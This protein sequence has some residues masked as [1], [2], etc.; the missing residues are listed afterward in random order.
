MKFKTTLILLVVF[1]L[2]LVGVILIEHRSE[3]AQEKREREAKLT[4]YQASEVEKI[5]L[6]SESGEKI[7]IERDQT[8]HWKIIEPL[9]AEADEYEINSLVE[10]FASLSFEKVVEEE[11]SDP[12][13]YEIPKKDITFWL[14]GHSQPI[15][16]QIGMENPI[17][18]TLYAKRAD[19]SQVVLLPGHLK[20]SLDKT[21]FDF[22]KK[23]IMT[24]DTT[25]VLAIELRAKENN[26]KVKRR[27]ENWYFLQPGE[28]LAS[29]SKIEN[30]LDSLSRLRA[31]D[32][33]AENKDSQNLKLFGLDKP[34]FT[35][36]LTLPESQEIT[37]WLTRQD[38]KV[39]VTNSLSKKIIEVDSQII[40]DLSQ[41]LTDLREKKVAV[42]NS[43]EAVALSLKQETGK[44]SVVKE[45]VKEKGQEEEK[46]FLMTAGGDK[47]PV[48]D[49]RVESLL[50]NLEYLEATD[51][52]DNPR[53]LAE[54]GLDRPSLEIT[55][56][57]RTD[58]DE[59][60]EL[61]LLVGP[62]NPET[63]QVVIK[64]Q[65]LPYL[66]RV[67]ASFLKEIPERPEDWKLIENNNRT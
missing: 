23:D 43:W 22:R 28:A 54:Y 66:F 39:T 48:D 64:N 9:E 17:D 51:F 36:I 58:G 21:L 56:R 31:K 10:N 30:L 63:H 34:E 15:T 2:L 3:R 27:E 5:S 46:W 6:K 13:L 18:N 33:L 4:D 35:V 29:K 49:Y 67:E 59:E 53:S 1:I 7:T 24:F 26:W 14:K 37:F 45:K 62:E 20:Y 19:Q 32:F 42:F 11:V 55:I 52:I 41:R 57:V 47:E 12:A 50:R 44:V 8:G 16:I 60:K 65:D 38:D 25:S 40:N 61:R